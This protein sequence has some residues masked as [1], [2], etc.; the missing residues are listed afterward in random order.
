MT[1]SASMSEKI[2]DHD[3]LAEFHDGDTRALEYFY[4]EQFSTVDRAVGRL[5]S[6][7]DRETVVHEVFFRIISTPELRRAFRGGSASAWIATVARNH[8]IDFCRR[9]Q[10]EVP[11]EEPGRGGEALDPSVSADV[12]LEAKLL[13][14]Q[15]CREVLPEKWRAVFEVCFLQGKTQREAATALGISRTTLLYQQHRVRALLEKFLLEDVEP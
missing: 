9:H 3:W 10:R 2:S 11:S 12:E 4:R 5:L 14:D 15:F 8:T 1:L 7:P 13:L 6:G